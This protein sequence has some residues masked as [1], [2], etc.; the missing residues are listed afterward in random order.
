MR[1]PVLLTAT[2]SISATLILVAYASDKDDGGAM[3]I[4]QMLGEEVQ[5]FTADGE[6]RSCQAGVPVSPGEYADTVRKAE[7]LMAKYFALAAADDQNALSALFANIRDARWNGP[8]GWRGPRAIRDPFARLIVEK[9]VRVAFVETGDEAVARGIWVVRVRRPDDP[10]ATM[11]VE[12]AVDFQRRYWNQFWLWH[13]RLYVE[14]EQ[15]PRPMAV[16][17]FD[18]RAAY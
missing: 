3:G 18:P 5:G 8:A 14:P 10:A 9:P 16:C 11:S 13:V 2:L 4:A 12:Y 1:L 17:H 7:A 6:E 15:A